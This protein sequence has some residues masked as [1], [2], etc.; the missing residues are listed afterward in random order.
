MWI[1]WSGRDNRTPLYR[2]SA[3]MRNRP[4]HG[5]GLRWNAEQVEEEVN[6]SVLAM[7]TNQNWLNEVEDAALR[8]P[9]E[10]EDEQREGLEAERKRAT[11]AYIAGALADNEWRLRLLTIDDRLARL[12]T[13]HVESPITHAE[14]LT[15]LSDIWEGASHEEKREALRCLFQGIHITVRERKVWVQPWPEL[16][17]LFAARQRWCSLTTPDRTRTCAFGFGGRHSIR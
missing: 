1:S 8:G 10:G 11:N 4:C 15:G 5:A 6:R 17:P 16:E 7:A 3:K 12:P 9:T 13:R 14:R 2:D